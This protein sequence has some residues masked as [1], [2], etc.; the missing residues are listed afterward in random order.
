MI[1][2]ERFEA[3]TI[4]E[5]DKLFELHKVNTDQGQ[6]CM[7]AAQMAKT[8]KQDGKTWRMK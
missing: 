5:L 6:Q 2:G 4:K 1:C 8:F 3:P 7:G